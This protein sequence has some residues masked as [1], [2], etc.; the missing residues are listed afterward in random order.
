VKTRAVA[1]KEWRK[2]YYEKICGLRT[3]EL[4]F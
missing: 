1:S 4:V 3:A 2:I